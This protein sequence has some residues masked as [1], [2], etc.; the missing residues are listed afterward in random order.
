MKSVADSSN[1]GNLKCLNIISSS[2]NTVLSDFHQVGDHLHVSC[3]GVFRFVDPFVAYT[4]RNTRTFWKLDPYYDM[5]VCSTGDLSQF[6]SQ[7][8]PSHKQTGQHFKSLQHTCRILSNVCVLHTNKLSTRYV[9]AVASL[10][11]HIS[12]R[13]SYVVISAALQTAH[14]QLYLLICWSMTWWSTSI[15]LT[16]RRQKI[17]YLKRVTPPWVVFGIDQAQT[18]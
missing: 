6:F 12:T 4:L 14:F 10:I 13:R 1:I 2:M 11:I 7:L 17:V 15:S 18:P 5:S 9:G 16:G 3:T 8:L